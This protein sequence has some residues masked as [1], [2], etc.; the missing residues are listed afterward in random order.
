M[1]QDRF[2]EGPAPFDAEERIDNV[3]HEFE[4]QWK[5]GESP[6]VEAFLGDAQGTERAALL[7][8]LLLLD[9][10]YRRRRGETPSPEEYE[11]RFPEDMAVVD[12]VRE[13]ARMARTTPGGAESITH[14]ETIGAYKIL[15]VVGEGGMGLVYLAEQKEPIYRRVAIK[16]IKPGMD[17]KA[18]I[19]RFEAERQVLALL[20]HP[21][22]AKV[23]EAGATTGGRPYFVMEYFP[24]EPITEYCDRNSLSVRERLRLSLPLCEAVCHAHQKGIIHRDI[25]PTNIL[26]SAHS[27]VPVPKIIDF[28]VAKATNL[29]LTEKTLYTQSGQIVGTPEYMSPEQAEMRAAGVDSRTDIYSLGVLLYEL[30]VGVLPLEP[31]EF[32]QASYAEIQRIIREKDP[33]RPSTRLTSLG[34]RSAVAADRRGTELRLLAR[35]L[36]GD[37]DWITMKAMDKEPARRYATAADLG[38]DIERYLAHEPV[39]A[40]PPRLGYRL[41]KWTKRR[42]R[43]LL[44]LITIFASM[45]LGAAW[46]GWLGGQKEGPSSGTSPLQGRTVHVKPGGAGLDGRSWGSAYADLRTAIEDANRLN[47][48]ASPANDVAEIWV[49]AGDYAFTAAMAV[50]GDVGIYGGFAGHETQRAQRD[51]A[52]H[53]TRISGRGKGMRPFQLAGRKNSTVID[54]FTISGFNPNCEGGVPSGAVYIHDS[55][56]RLRN[57]RFEDNVAPRGGAIFARGGVTDLIVEGC[58]FVHNEVGSHGGALYLTE[59]NATIRDCRFTGNIAGREAQA[60]GGAVFALGGRLSIHGCRFTGN[61]AGESGGAITVVSCDLDVSDSVFRGNQ[62]GRRAEGVGRFGVSGGALDAVKTS[63]YDYRL[64]LTGC[65]FE[66]NQAVGA[67]A[68][69]GALSISGATALLTNCVLWKNSCRGYYSANA[70][71]ISLEAGDPVAITNCTITGNY[72]EIVEALPGGTA[73]TSRSTIFLQDEPGKG[74][75]RIANTIVA[76]NGKVESDLEANLGCTVDLDRY[77]GEEGPGER[78]ELS[79]ERSCIYPAVGELD[80]ILRDYG[81]PRHIRTEDPVFREDSPRVSDA[82]PLIDAG[83]SS[84]DV[85]PFKDGVQEVKT[86]VAGQSRFVDGDDD[87]DV[88]VDIGAYELQRDGT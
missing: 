87:G 57:I 27:G 86:D 26:V 43:G 64:E 28:G 3:C 70:S 82:S 37:L 33:L 88:R 34:P 47:S 46:M 69:G 53:T 83:D 68:S 78:D 32:R 79:I 31:T 84:V 63:Y 36:R 12:A 61:V 76:N 85:D 19:A 6:R 15:D 24:G 49:G 56:V 75:V 52:A 30:L 11:A 81:D 45:M 1:T 13:S 73:L 14:P 51:P 8:E 22:I 67:T 44:V 25:K 74:R 55:R 40:G 48:D 17:T 35:Q 23:Y 20:D 5:R 16:V 59:G 4:S 54:G 38:R 9:L 72:N 62:A 50:L 71:A 39:S 77:S 18:V 65:T 21:N 58:E 66:G 80:K 60:H 42:S 2:D 10:D 7:R 29:R 41:R